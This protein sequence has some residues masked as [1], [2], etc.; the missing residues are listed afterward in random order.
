[1]TAEKEGFQKVIRS[2]I[3]LQI[4]QKARVDM[5]LQVGAVTQTV[6]VGGQAPL[7]QTASSEHSE[8]ITSDQIVSLP[9]NDRNFSQLVALNTG[10]VPD[11]GDAVGP[12]NPQG[13]SYMHV[14]GTDS[15]ANNWI[16]DG[17]SDNESFFSIITVNPSL[18]AI[19]E[20]KVST[21]DYAAEFGRAGG[22]NVQISIKSGTN[23]SQNEATPHPRDVQIT[24]SQFELPS[25]E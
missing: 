9:M 2:G 8:V 6:E 20:F 7:V 5:T 23:Q 1:V 4:D 22:A 24:S 15:G 11:P 17:I 12:D 16:I 3:T 14:N 19:Q 25:A 21:S 13:M 18:D 10:G